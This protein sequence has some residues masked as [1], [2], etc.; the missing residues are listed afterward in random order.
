MLKVHFLNVGK[1]TIQF[2]I[3]ILSVII[4]SFAIANELSI[5]SVPPTQA[6]TKVLGRTA[7][8][9]Y[10]DGEF[11]KNSPEKVKQ[12]LQKLSKVGVSVYLNSPGGNLLAGVEIGRLIR[13]MAIDTNIGKMPSKNNHAQPGECYSA[14]AL[15]FLGGPY[16]YI[17]KGS[18]Y[19]VHR[20][21]RSTGSESMDLE[22]GQILS[23]DIASYIREMGANPGLFDLMV[24]AGSNE[25][26]LLSEHEA[27]DLYVVNNGRMSPEWSIEATPQGT[28]LKGV[29]DTVYGEG[30]LMFTCHKDT[31]IIFS[32]YQAGDRA[33]LIANSGWV[34]SLM[35]DE[36]VIS[37]P[38]PSMI[39]N[40][41]DFIESLFLLK[42][43]QF[44]FS[45]VVLAKSIGHAMQPTRKAPTYVGYNVDIDS[46]SEQRVRNYIGN[47]SQI[48]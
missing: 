3:I 18:V 40:K 5:T 44:P 14:C 23:A 39:T 41:G 1:G 10:I 2:L 36:D 25:I 48:K 11:D 31:I 9:M 20:A 13:K 8:T 35:I 15:A 21:S 29:Q 26:Y 19:G 43:S 42:N 37:L 27:K 6:E 47:C 46:K 32:F 12:E 22:V 16:R 30:K 24:K 38:T 45:Q 17:N 34:H 33:K 28:Y 7:W 4:N